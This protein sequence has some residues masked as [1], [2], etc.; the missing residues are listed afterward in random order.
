MIH[1]SLCK[2]MAKHKCDPMRRPNICFYQH[3]DDWDN[4]Y[5]GIFE[6]FP[7]DSKKEL[8]KRGGQIIREIGTVN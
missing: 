5:I 8:N 6:N 1:S 2:R 3:V 7:C 4:W